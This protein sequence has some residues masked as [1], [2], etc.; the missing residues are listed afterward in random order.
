M[1]NDGRNGTGKHAVPWSSPATLI[2]SAGVSDPPPPHRAPKSDPPEVKLKKKIEWAKWLGGIVIGIFLT[3]F[4]AAQYVAAFARTDEVHAE[5]QQYRED[6]AHKHED[7]DRRLAAIETVT[8][9]I[10]IEQART[11]ER[12]RLIDARIE[13]L[14]ERTRRGRRAPAREEVLEDQIRIHEHRVLSAERDPVGLLD[15]AALPRTP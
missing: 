4:G 9:E 13:L 15:I 12:Q 14:L 10:R 6:H 1:A 5:A 7:L 2:A 8:T 11:A 3:G